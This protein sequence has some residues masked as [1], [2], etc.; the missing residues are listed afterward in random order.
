[1][2]EPHGDVGLRLALGRGRR[3]QR[4]LQCIGECIVSVGDVQP[5]Y[6]I[7]I[8]DWTAPI[9]EGLRD[10][11]QDIDIGHRVSMANIRLDDAWLGWNVKEK[12]TL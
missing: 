11:M 5:K 9:A 12:A 10:V 6:N 2:R 3:V 1:M 7:I 4:Q 8:L